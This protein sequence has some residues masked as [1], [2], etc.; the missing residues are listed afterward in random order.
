VVGGHEHDRVVAHEGEG[1]ADLLVEVAVVVAH[2]RLVG[3]ARDVL[4]VLRVVE[5]Q[6]P[7]CIRSRPISMNWK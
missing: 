6:N 7:W 2:H 4:A 1:A 5:L 3:V